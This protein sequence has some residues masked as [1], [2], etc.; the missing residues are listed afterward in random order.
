M[1]RSEQRPLAVK[2]AR[3]ALGVAT[4]ALVVV[5]GLL[6]WPRSG[7]APPVD[8]THSAPPATVA[9]ERLDLADQQVLPGLLGF[10]NPTPVFG[11]GPG[12]VT[13]LPAPGKVVRR[14]KQ[15]Y[16]VDDR[17]ITV[18]LGNTPFYRVLTTSGPPPQTGPTA[19]GFQT[20]NDVAVLKKNLRA[21]GYPVGTR[22][23]PAYTPALAAG[24]RRWQKDVGLPA[25]GDF[26]PAWVSVLPTAVRVESVAGVLGG[27]AEAQLL[28]VTSTARS[29]AVRLTPVQAAAYPVGTA[30]TVTLADGT[31]M[32]GS[33]TAVTSV[34]ADDG[35]RQDIATVV[36]DK[37]KTVNAAVS[38][39]VHVTFTG[40]ARHG[41]LAVPVA[42][43]LALASGGYGLESTDGTLVA[44]KT[45]LFADGL[46]EVSGDGVTEGL[47]VVT[48]G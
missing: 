42:A 1:S 39:A 3:A 7:D 22:K 46:V 24:V 23:D 33:L 43:L 20:G 35:A 44:V 34:P 30:V 40:K 48:A 14:G 29:V 25:T 27:P 4:L 6:L 12:I 19:G 2:G 11:H 31:T 17:P 13:F 10:G 15:L 32:P 45:G 37:A 47:Q 16:R 41:V 38:D 28:S 8:A 21:L 36:G 9:V 5:G 18:F 26:D